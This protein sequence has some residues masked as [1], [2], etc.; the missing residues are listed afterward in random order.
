[1]RIIG[2]DEADFL[3]FAR[4]TRDHAVQVLAFVDVA[5]IAAGVFRVLAFGP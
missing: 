5:E 1:M 4:G 2:S 3:G